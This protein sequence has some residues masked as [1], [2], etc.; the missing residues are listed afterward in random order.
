MNARDIETTLRARASFE[1]SVEHLDRDTRQRLRAIR[2]RTLDSG[3][4]PSIWARWAWP[5]GAAATA[6]LA[7]AVFMPHLPHAPVQP[8]GTTT[9][10]DAAAVVLAA[11]ASPTASTAMDAAIKPVLATSVTHASEA[12]TIE[13][14]DPDMLSDL[15]FYDWLS[16]QQSE[17]QNTGG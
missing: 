5:A 11:A 6:A 15:D 13:T 2:V 14:A 1:A 7:L 3:A 8:V 4:R 9:R 17:S 16:R 10:S 12:G